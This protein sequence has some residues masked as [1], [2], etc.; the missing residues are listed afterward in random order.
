MKD[1]FAEI[2]AMKRESERLKGIDQ[3]LNWTNPGP[4]GFYDDLGNPAQ[5]PHLVRPCAYETDPESRV[6]PLTNFDY[7]PEARLSWIRFAEGR[8][9]AALRMRYTGLDPEARYSVRVVYAGETERV[10]VRL[11]ANE[12][13]EVHPFITKEYPLRPVEFDIP[14]SA[15]SGG[16]LTL[17]WYQE[18]GIGGNGRGCQVAEVWLIKK[19]E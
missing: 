12:E 7:L 19:T 5:S 2:R 18:P 4:G 9:D 16:V 10:K 1:R 13:T 6:A 8:Y 11:L 17:T 14:A 15:T 3:I